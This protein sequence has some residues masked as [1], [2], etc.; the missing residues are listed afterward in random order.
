MKLEGHSVFFQ[1]KTLTL[2]A[3]WVGAGCAGIFT[4]HAALELYCEVFEGEGALDRF[5]AC[6][7]KRNTLTRSYGFE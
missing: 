5:V 1:E 7:L 6:G 2:G 3:L 4:G